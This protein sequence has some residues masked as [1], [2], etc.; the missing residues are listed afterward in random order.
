MIRYSV[1]P[2]KKLEAEV[3]RHAPGWLAEAKKRTA[4]FKG[5]GAYFEPPKPNWS[6]VKAVYMKYQFNKCAYCEQ[7]LAGG[8]RGAIE[9]DIEHFRPKSNVAA[10][11]NKKKLKRLGYNFPTGDPGG[12]YHLLPYNIFNYATACKVCNSSLKRDFFPVSGARVTDSDSPRRLKREKP[13]LLY[14]LGKLDEDDPEELI[15][16]GGGATAASSSAPLFAQPRPNPALGDPNKIRRAKV[17]IDFF[18]LDI[19]EPLIKQ[20]AEVVKK[21][22]EAFRDQAIHPDADRRKRAAKDLTRWRKASSEHTSCARSFYRLCQ[23]DLN[24]ALAA[25]RA[26]VTYIDQHPE[27]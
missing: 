10:W 3:E 21:M 23:T 5:K 16:F 22:F 24:A 15:V 26:A 18:E 11:P 7:K 17:T 25:Y 4:A 6:K 13:F 19:R 2:R 20:R 14:P 8:E 12:G 27:L 1:P 9:H